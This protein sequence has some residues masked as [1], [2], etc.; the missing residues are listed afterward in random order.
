[1]IKWI[2]ENLKELF[3]PP[4]IFAFQLMVFNLFNN[5]ETTLERKKKRDIGKSPQSP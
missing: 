5:I 2:D 1:M 4:E 3:S